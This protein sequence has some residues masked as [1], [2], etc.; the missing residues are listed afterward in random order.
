MQTDAEARIKQDLLVEI[1]NLEQNYTVIKSF[2]AGK[3]Y[4]VEVIGTSI[5]SFKDSLNRASAY[6][7]AL[8]NLKGKRVNIPWDPLFTSLDYAIATLTT[9]PKRAAVA[10]ILA[11]AQSQMEQVMSY[12]VALKESIK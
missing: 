8:Y 4:D 10:A 2:V 11:M 1:H 12:F 6:V 9:A 3:D 5:Q 7:L